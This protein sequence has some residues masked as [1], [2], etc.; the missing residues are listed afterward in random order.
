MPNI[1]VTPVTEEKHPKLT[2]TQHIHPVYP[3]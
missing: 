3:N 1:P 2:E